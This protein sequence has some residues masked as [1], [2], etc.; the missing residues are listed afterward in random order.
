ML[1]QCYNAMQLGRA[2]LLDVNS[3]DVDGQQFLQWLALL[4]L[5]QPRVPSFMFMFRHSEIHKIH[6]KPQKLCN[7][8]IQKFVLP[9]PRVPSFGDLSILHVP[10]GP[11]AQT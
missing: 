1:R 8:E 3:P 11:L 6:S 2:S 4:V 5:P 7:S 10:S 9:Q